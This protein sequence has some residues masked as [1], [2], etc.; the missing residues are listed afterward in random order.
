MSGLGE[1]NWEGVWPPYGVE[2]M[3]AGPD[4]RTAPERL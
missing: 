3:P 4:L 2:Q 1:R